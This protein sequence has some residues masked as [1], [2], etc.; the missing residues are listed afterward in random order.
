MR[1]LRMSESIQPA[2]T[3]PA[4]PL[5]SATGLDISYSTAI[6]DKWGTAV[7]AGFQ[8]LPDTLL[9]H[10]ARQGLTSVDLVVLL[11][12]LMAWWTVAAKPYPRVATLANRMQVS[13]RTVQRSLTRMRAMGIL[14][15]ERTHVN[16]TRRRRSSLTKMTYA[17][18]RGQ[19]AGALRKIERP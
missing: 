19:P 17:R 5:A 7:D 11:N 9:R 14:S 2:E 18:M 8:V 15:W 12:L 13:P 3:T 16:G 4:S 1:V 6:T 10:Y